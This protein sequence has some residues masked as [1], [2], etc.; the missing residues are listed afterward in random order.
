MY[1]YG[2]Q[3]ISPL[4]WQQS[5]AWGEFPFFRMEL[6]H[7]QG[8]ENLENIPKTFSPFPISRTEYTNFETSRPFIPDLE[9]PIPHEPG[10]PSPPARRLFTSIV[11]SPMGY[12]LPETSLVVE[13]NVIP[14]PSLNFITN[15]YLNYL[16]P[17]TY[18]ESTITRRTD[19]PKYLLD[20]HI[21]EKNDDGSQR[22]F[23][24]ENK[25]TRKNVGDNADDI[26]HSTS[27]N[28]SLAVDKYISVSSHSTPAI[29]PR[30]STLT[31][32]TTT[33]NVLSYWDSPDNRV[34]PGKYSHVMNG[35]YN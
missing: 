10:L 4:H 11:E 29:T 26:K 18:K 28:A 25:S 30:P 24:P 14:A 21:Y 6:P 27:E 5:N 16:R 20:S 19:I 31:T 2:A 22:L 13:K 9:I 23:T 12:F 35:N 7:W 8:N 32:T 1:G 34:E 33:E 17:D 15:V 3:P